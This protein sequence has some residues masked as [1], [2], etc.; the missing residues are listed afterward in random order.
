[1]RKVLLVTLLG[2]AL[3]MNLYAIINEVIS[4]YEETHVEE[5]NGCEIVYME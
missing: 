4:Y 1:M 2:L 5:I 3:A